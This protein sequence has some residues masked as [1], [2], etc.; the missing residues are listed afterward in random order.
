VIRFDRR[1]HGFGSMVGEYVGEVPSI[2]SGG[3]DSTG[4]VLTIGV[5]LVASH[6]YWLPFGPGSFADADGYPLQTW[7]L[8]F[9][10]RAEP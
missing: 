9:K 6:S 3:F 4:T 8:R 7:E 10:T 1:V 2:T 5:R